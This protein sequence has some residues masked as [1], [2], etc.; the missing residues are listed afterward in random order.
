[1]KNWKKR[2][3]LESTC[4]GEVLYI[5][6]SPDWRGEWEASVGIKYGP[7]YSGRS[8]RGK[9]GIGA[10][11]ALRARMVEEGRALLEMAAALPTEIPE[12]EP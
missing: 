2:V 6:C 11:N 1:M 3:S 8:E 4:N 10:L 5:R 7:S 12:T 9:T